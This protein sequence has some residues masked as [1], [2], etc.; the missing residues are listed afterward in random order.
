MKSKFYLLLSALFIGTLSYSQ[1]K[2]TE[3]TRLIKY[4]A[5]SLNW[6][7]RYENEDY[8]K[9]TESDLCSLGYE[10]KGINI[11]T[12]IVYT[13]FR[14]TISPKYYPQLNKNSW[15]INTKA[16]SY[17]QILSVKFAFKDD[18]GVDIQEFTLLAERIK[19]EVR[20]KLGFNKV[21]PDLFYLQLTFFGPKL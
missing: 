15:L 1:E 13:I 7:L 19:N 21:N 10:L 20:W 2:A 17:G 11:D 14:R 4:T 5:N 6:A 16:T 18:S 9:I 8:D 12:S 3:Q